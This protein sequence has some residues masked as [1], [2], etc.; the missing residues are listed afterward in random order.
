MLNMNLCLCIFKLCNNI[1]II[2]IT[3]GKRLEGK[4]GG[5][6]TPKNT[7]QCRHGPSMRYWTSIGT[8]QY[9]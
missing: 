9:Q 4:G 2:C 6:S 8:V 7:G 1:C 3:M 5:L